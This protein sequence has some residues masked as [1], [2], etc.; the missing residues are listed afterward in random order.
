MKLTVIGSGC[1]GL[2]AGACLSSTGKD[3]VIA[4]IDGEKVELLRA[5]RLPTYERGLKVMRHLYA[6]FM[7]RR[8]RMPVLAPASAELTKYACN[9]MLATRISFMNEMARLCE[10]YGANIDQLRRGMG[11]GRRIGPEFLYPSLGCGGRN[12]SGA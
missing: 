10:H 8:E 6:P 9:C 11:L 12:G 2:V 4:D 5:R 3:V 1:V 7:L